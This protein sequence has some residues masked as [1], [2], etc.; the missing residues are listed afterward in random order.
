MSES[1]RIEVVLHR[2]FPEPVECPRYGQPIF[3]THCYITWTSMVNWDGSRFTV[4]VVGPRRKKNGDPY[5]EALVETFYGKHARPW[6]VLAGIAED[7]IAN[8]LAE[9]AGQI[10]ERSHP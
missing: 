4:K 6:L 5:D 10:S 8:A 7:N 9:A 1:P 2:E 3:A